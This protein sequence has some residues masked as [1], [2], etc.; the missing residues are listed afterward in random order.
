M[1]SNELERLPFPDEGAIGASNNLAPACMVEGLSAQY[2]PYF[3]PPRPLL[4]AFSCSYLTSAYTFESTCLAYNGTRKHEQ[5]S[6]ALQRSFLLPKRLITTLT[7]SIAT[8]CSPAGFRRSMASRQGTGGSASGAS[9]STRT[10]S[11]WSYQYKNHCLESALRDYPQRP[12]GTCR[13]RVS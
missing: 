12:N 3:L 6:K 7:H 5:D 11:D 10:T 8:C 4:L 13:T 9:N 1:P 2:A